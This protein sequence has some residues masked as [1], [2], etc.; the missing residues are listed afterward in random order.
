MLPLVQV[1]GWLIARCPEFL[2][3]AASR[4]IGAALYYGY[5]ARRR[6][7]LTSLGHSFP[8]RDP[9]WRRRIALT[10]CVRVVETGFLSLGAP[11]LSEKRIRRMASASQAT[12]SYFEDVVKKRHPV[13]LGTV[14]LAYWEGLTWLRAF[15]TPA[16]A[17]TEIVTIFRPLRTPALDD[18]LRRTRERFGVRMI[19]RKAGLHAALHTLQRNGIA[20]ILF[21]QSAGSHGYLTKFF[22]RECST[23]P[24]PGM[25]VERS[26]ADVAIIFTRRLAFW[27]FEI[28]L[29]PVATDRTEK[30][31]TL[32]LNREFESLLRRDENVCASWLWLHQRWRILDRPGEM[33]KLVERRG[34]LIE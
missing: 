12:R 27:H 7:M 1:I 22:G 24:L 20:S 18:W 26:G 6:L 32:A 23:T 31:V 3:A 21:D 5:P 28:D 11:F 9:A 8:E 17:D 16:L 29:I 33:A 25:L 4:V 10:S 19:S 15:V 30:G 13:V 34:G 14:H 2:L